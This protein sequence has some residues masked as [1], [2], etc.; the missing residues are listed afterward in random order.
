MY[1][2]EGFHE[3]LLSLVDPAPRIV[4]PPGTRLAAVLVPVLVGGPHPRLVFTKRTDTL[5]RHAGEISFP[6]GLTD[7]DEELSGAALRE[8]EEEL[9][10]A[11]ADVELAGALPPVHTHVSGI[12]IAPFVGT[13]RKD[14]RFTPNAA[15]IEEVLEFPLADLMSVGSER[16]FEHDGRRFQTYVYEMD[17]YVIWGATAKI[18]WSFIGLLRRDPPATEG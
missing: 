3:R 2:S 16:E 11:P 15:E 7:D 4:P 12:L 13:I 8:A 18:L 10:L 17:G 14:P 6:G 5:S 1:A 9:G